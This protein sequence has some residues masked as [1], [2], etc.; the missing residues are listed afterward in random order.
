MPAASS[1]TS[2]EKTDGGPAFPVDQAGEPRWSGMTLRDYFAGQVVAV[3]LKRHP[4]EPAR[5]ATTAY[6][7]AD[8]MLAARAR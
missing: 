2:A 7:F 6:E 5:V 8:A 3:I 1:D 4:G